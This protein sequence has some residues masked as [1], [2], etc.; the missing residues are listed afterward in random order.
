VQVEGDWDATQMAAEEWDNY[1]EYIDIV[2]V[3]K[4]AAK[5]DAVRVYIVQMCEGK[6]VVFI[7]ARVDNG[8]IGVKAVGSGSGS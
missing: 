4:H 8:L 2:Q 3:V 7:L 1:E 5:Q 6:F